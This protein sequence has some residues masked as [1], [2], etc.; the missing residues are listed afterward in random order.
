MNRYLLSGSVVVVGL[1]ASV[2]LRM[3]L[4]TSIGLTVTS[5]RVTH[6][7]SVSLISFWFVLIVTVVLSAYF[8]LR[9]ST[10]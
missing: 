5:N 4:P 1:I 10:R 3:A 7:F 8:S 6:Y 2:V 9:S